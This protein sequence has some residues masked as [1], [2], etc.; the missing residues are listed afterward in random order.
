MKT[1]I[2]VKVSF[3]QVQRKCIVKCCGILLNNYHVNAESLVIDVDM[4][5]HR[6]CLS[7]AE[8][9]VGINWNTEQTIQRTI[10]LPYSKVIDLFFAIQE[11][12]AF[13]QNELERFTS[14]EIISKLFLIII[15]SPKTTK[16][17][18]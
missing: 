13:L 5:R 2:S 1:K 12:N 10:A 3:T 4:M 7:L 18:G 14:M 15:E 8:L 9:M 17:N 6:Y 16:H 11:V